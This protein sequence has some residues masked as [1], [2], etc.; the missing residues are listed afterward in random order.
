MQF[1]HANK[2]LNRQTGRG[3]WMDSSWTLVILKRDIKTVSRRCQ[4]WLTLEKDI[5][6]EVYEKIVS[7]LTINNIVLGKNRRGER[8]EGERSVRRE[9]KG[10]KWKG[11][12]L[13][14]DKLE[15]KDYATD[16]GICPLNCIIL[17]NSL[18]LVPIWYIFTRLHKR[19]F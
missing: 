9:E 13:C 15:S 17:L 11:R 19:A 10:N 1:G 5:E 3:H 6:E 18:C 12:K 2:W 7:L 14:F 16:Y 4:K 8:N